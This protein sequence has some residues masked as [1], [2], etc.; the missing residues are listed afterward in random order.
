[1]FR[2]HTGNSNARVSTTIVGALQIFGLILIS[3]CAGTPETHT[4]APEATASFIVQGTDLETVRTA[5]EAASFTR[6]AP[7]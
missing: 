6:W 3:S 1:M 5:V 4:S 2:K 7:G